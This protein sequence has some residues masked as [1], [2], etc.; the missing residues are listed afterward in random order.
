MLFHPLYIEILFSGLN[1]VLGN[2]DFSCYL[3][4]MISDNSES[5]LKC[6]KIMQMVQGNRRD[7]NGES[8]IRERAVN[9]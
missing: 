8:I 5:Y 4:V 3:P 2:P 6:H 1:L 9:S 7:I